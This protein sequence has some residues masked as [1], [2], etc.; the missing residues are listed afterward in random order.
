[1][2]VERSA[3]EADSAH[4]RHEL[5]GTHGGVDR[6]GL[7]EEP[8]HRRVVAVG[9]QGGGAPAAGLEADEAGGGRLAAEGHG[10]VSG[11][12]Q[13]LGDVGEGAGLEQGRGGQL[14]VGRRPGQLPHGQAVAVGGHEDQR[15]ALDLDLDAG[16]QR[17]GVVAGGGD[18]DLADGAG[19]V[20]G[21]DLPATAGMTG[22]AG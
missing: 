15:A 11:R 4:G 2:G 13:G 14:G 6:G 10:H 7:R 16:E 8:A 3:T 12:G 17:Q 9:E 1:M 20:V 5:V 19:Q 21:V 18:G 22:S